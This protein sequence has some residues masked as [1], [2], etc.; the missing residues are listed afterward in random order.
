MN[1]LHVLSL[2]LIIILILATAAALLSYTESSNETANASASVYVGVAFG[3]NTTEQAKLLIDRTKTYT[4]LFILNAGRNSISTNES[5]V[6]EICDYATNANLNIIVNLG[7][8]TRENWQWQLQFI[9]NSK[10][11]YGDKFLGVYYDDEPMGIPFDW[12][13]PSVFARNSSAFL[14]PTYQLCSHFSSELKPL[15]R[16]GNYLKI[17]Q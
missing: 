15:S 12:N 8:R 17:T 2:I 4:N 1:R 6:K 13:W 16:Q 9:N 14:T 3:G 11:N 5:A 10:N 7:I